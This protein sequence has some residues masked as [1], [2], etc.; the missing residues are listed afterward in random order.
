MGEDLFWAFGGGGGGSFGIVLAWKI[1][2]VRVPAT[3]TVFTVRRTLE[4][5]ATRL[6][7]QWQYVA[8]KLP[9]E[10]KMSIGISRVKSSQDEKM[11]IQA[12]FRSMFLGGIDKLVP[13]MKERFPE[14]GLE[15]ED[16]TEMSWA[17]SNL[18]FSQARI[19]VPLEALL[20]R[21]QKSALSKLFFKAKSDF[22]KEPIP[23]MAFEG[24]W[25]K[26]FEEEA[27]SALMVLVAWGG[28][29]DEILETE[30][31]YPHRAG[32]IYSILYVVNWE[33]KEN[34]YSKR[35]VSWMRRVYK[36][37]KPYVSKSPREAYVNY[38]DLDIGTNNNNKNKNLARASIWGLKYFKNNFNR[39]V[40]VKTTI[41]PENFFRNEQSIPP[42]SSS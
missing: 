30:T 34:T 21:S 15:K 9:K 29:M 11:T 26:F 36:Y 13:L 22:V 39:L 41:D 24:L 25:P 42:L 31:P 35:Y 6:I 40:H 10:I 20:G 32:N 4:Q 23:K 27:K 16:C 33:E 2:L 14:L 37:M 18:Y 28:K 3:V 17:E 1:K 5:N 8:H 19:G 7:H 38:R 12:L